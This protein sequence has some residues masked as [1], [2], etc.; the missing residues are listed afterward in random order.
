[1]GETPGPR[2][3]PFGAVPLS[4]FG[5]T[6]WPRGTPF[7]ATDGDVTIPLGGDICI[8]PGMPDGVD[9]EATLEMD[10]E[11][12]E[13]EVEVTEVVDATFVD[14]VAFTVVVG[15]VKSIPF[16]PVTSTTEEI[17]SLLILFT[18]YLPNLRALQLKREMS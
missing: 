9:G 11:E 10:I 16:T 8:P 6:P 17:L 4:P 13:N 3:V 1:M 2:G 15:I 18:K 7:G 12:D 5:E 14:V